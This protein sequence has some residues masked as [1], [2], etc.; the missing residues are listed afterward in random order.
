MVAA[1]PVA[2]YPGSVRSGIVR[3]YDQNRRHTLVNGMD[4]AVA[5]VG[6]DSTQRQRIWLLVIALPFANTQ[7]MKAVVPVGHERH[8]RQTVHK[9]TMNQLL[10]NTR[11][12]T[13]HGRA[14]CFPQP[15][16]LRSAAQVP[17]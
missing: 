8:E 10:I 1:T 12:G 16:P 4:R 13:P 9:R 17:N 7:Q 11:Y 5:T 6:P 2:T 15:H 14:E 3:L